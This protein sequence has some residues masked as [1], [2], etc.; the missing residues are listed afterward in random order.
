M[1]PNSYALF[2]KTSKNELYG[3][4]SNSHKRLGF[5]E[6]KGWHFEELQFIPIQNI[7]LV[8]TGIDNEYHSFILTNNNILYGTGRNQ[9]GCLAQPNDDNAHYSKN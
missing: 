3:V 5:E 6:A 8:S 1:Y 2:I 9:S 4:G 7:N